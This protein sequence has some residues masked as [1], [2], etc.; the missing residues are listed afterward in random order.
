MTDL[1]K[2]IHKKVFTRDKK[3]V[4]KDL[5][6]S[7]TYDHPSNVVMSLMERLEPMLTTELI[8]RSVMFHPLDV[9]PS[10][11][12]SKTICDHIYLSLSLNQLQCL[13]IKRILDHAIRNKG[14]I[15]LELN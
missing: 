2:G 11:S 1:W 14:K 10:D 8:S 6:N 5:N 13:I 7:P 3:R 4:D 9:L 12:D 15:Y